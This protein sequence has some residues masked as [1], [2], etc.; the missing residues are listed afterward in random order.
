[1][2]QEKKAKEPRVVFNHWSPDTC[3]CTIEFKWTD[4]DDDR[5]VD[6]GELVATRVIRCCEHHQGM[7]DDPAGLYE[8]LKEENRLKNESLQAL[9]DELPE[10]HADV[11]TDAETGLRSFKKIPKWDYGEGRELRIRAPAG[12]ADADFHAKCAHRLKE[13][14]GRQ[15]KW[16]PRTVKLVSEE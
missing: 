7:R 2:T 12:I 6:E 13:A 3:G 16:R 14:G 1:M 10:G 5:V 8:E 11:A 4:Y 9:L 15:S